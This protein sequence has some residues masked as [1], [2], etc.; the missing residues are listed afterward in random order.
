MMNHPTMPTRITIIEDNRVFARTIETFFNRPG[1]DV[2]CA[3]VYTTAEEALENL[4]AI[5]PDLV[6]VD[7]NLPGM[8]GIDCIARIKTL[9]P[10]I[11]SIILTAFE[12]DALI[13]EALK[14]GASGY[15]LKRSSPEE[16]IEA[17]KQ[18]VSGGAPMSPQIARQVVNFFYHE[19]TVQPGHSLSPREQEVIELLADGFLYKEIAER[20]NLT[21]E[22]VRTYVKLIYEKLQAHSRMD[23]VTKWRSLGARHRPMK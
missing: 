12:E 18:A 17:V 4:A 2:I 21:F 8:S 7:I 11:I 9:H 15:L 23:A 1:S 13:F 3:A 20:L 6:I 10:E 5:N 16:L 22:T 19:P 14:A